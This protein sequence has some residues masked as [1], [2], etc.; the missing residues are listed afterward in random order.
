MTAYSTA[1][2]PSSL[3]TNRCTAFTKP[4]IVYSLC[5]VFP[6][7]YGTILLNLFHPPSLRDGNVLRQVPQWIGPLNPRIGTPRTLQS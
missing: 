6:G 7:W 2:G 3:T 4:F 1:V 5:D